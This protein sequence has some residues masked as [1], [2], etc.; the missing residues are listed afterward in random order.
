MA[1]IQVNNFLSE[2]EISH[3][4]A[5]IEL[6]TKSYH[7]PIIKDCDK[8]KLSAIIE[9][10]SNNEVLRVLT[11]ELA[12]DVVSLLHR[13]EDSAFEFT[14]SAH[15][16]ISVLRSMKDY[17]FGTELDNKEDCEVRQFKQDFLKA[18]W[19]FVF[20]FYNDPMFLTNLQTKY[21]LT[22][23]NLEKF[24]NTCREY[25][26]K[27][28]LKNKTMKELVEW[29]LKRKQ[30]K[31]FFS[32]FY[33]QNVS[34]VKPWITQAI[35]VHKTT[36][37]FVRISYNDF[38]FAL[39]KVNPFKFDNSKTLR[40]TRDRENEACKYCDGFLVPP[41]QNSDWKSSEVAKEFLY[42]SHYQIPS[43]EPCPVEFKLPEAISDQ[44]AIFDPVKA[45][46]I[47]N[48]KKA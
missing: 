16:I 15:E 3:T 34:K 27:A 17:L 29:F 23:E 7:G 26:N 20:I 30:F 28:E 9:Y 25:S 47:K 13:F 5:F 2:A 42:R 4:M 43:M 18:Y 37:M 22:Y 12:Q 35:F 45:Y 24:T 1:V 44:T 6:A 33:D 32:F 40:F 10:Y 48:N 19:E 21:K 14:T 39:F 11:E 31:P 36:N 46:F 38:K 41:G 8:A